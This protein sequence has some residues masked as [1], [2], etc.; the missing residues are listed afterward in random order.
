MAYAR[1]LWVFSCLTGTDGLYPCHVTQLMCHSFYHFTRCAGM[2]SG[3]GHCL[4]TIK[5]VCSPVTYMFAVC[6]CFKC[7]KLWQQASTSQPEGV[8]TL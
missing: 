5:Q 1:Y 2:T 4:P 6:T 8:D 3:L 7:N